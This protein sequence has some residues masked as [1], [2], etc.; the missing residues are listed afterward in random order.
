MPGVNS[1]PI[2]VDRAIEDSTVSVHLLLES[3]A[4]KY[5]VIPEPYSG[6]V[7]QYDIV[8]RLRPD[9]RRREKEDVRWSTRNEEWLVTR[10][11]LPGNV[12]ALV[13]P[14]STS[15]KSLSSKVV[16]PVHGARQSAS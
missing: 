5:N 13:R 14:N 2:E 10:G 3:I 9:W 16:A 15:P 7:D 4:L 12:Q 11:P 8:G 6:R 1:K